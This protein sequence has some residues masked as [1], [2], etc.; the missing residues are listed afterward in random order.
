VALLEAGRLRL[1]EPTEVLQ[2][3]FRRVE[4]SGAPPGAAAEPGWL[5]WDRAGALTRFI[6]TGYAGEA[7]ERKWQEKFAG[8]TVNAAPMTLREIFMVLARAGRSRTTEASA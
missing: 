4:I 5:E 2:G 6:E 1:S 8:A 7:T 3:R